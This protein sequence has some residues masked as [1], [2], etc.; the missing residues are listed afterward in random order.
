MIQKG[1]PAMFGVTF[2]APGLPVA[3]RVFDSAGTPVG[4]WVAMPN[5]DGNS[6]QLPI[7]FAAVG[8]YSVKKVV[9]TSGAFT[10]RDPDRSEAD[11]AVQVVDVAA[12]VWD[13]LT[14]S[15]MASGS[16]GTAVGQQSSAVANILPASVVGYLSDPEPVLGSVDNLDTPVGVL[17]DS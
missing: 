7:T 16:F 8:A 15:Y 6:Y 14:A 3:A 13:A 1:K 9:F 12:E 4:P 11:D 17:E 2:D 5:Y 10:T